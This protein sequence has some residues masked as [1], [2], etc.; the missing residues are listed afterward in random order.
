VSGDHPS[1]TELTRFVSGG[2]ADHRLSALLA[3]LA[4]CSR[5]NGELSRTLLGRGEDAPTALA[6]APKTRTRSGSYD[7]IVRRATARAH[8]AK[9]RVE[10]EDAGARRLLPRLLAVPAGRREA[11]VR[12]DPRLQTYSFARDLLKRSQRVGIDDP[13]TGEQLGELALAVVG[14]LPTR[15]YGL[16][17]LTDLQ[18]E[19]WALIGNA[20]RIRSDFP[21]ATEALDRAEEVR[22][23]GSG[24]LME[25]A[26][27]ASL[28]A[29]HLRGSGRRREALDL[30]DHAIDLY[31][32]LGDRHLE[33][34]A[35]MS[36][37]ITLYEGDAPDEAIRHLDRAA[38][39]IDRTR[40]PRLPGSLEHNRAF[41]VGLAESGSGIVQAVG[42]LERQVPE[43]HLDRLRL[44]WSKAL[45]LRRL[46]RFDAAEHAL[47]SAHRGFTAA[48]IPADV[49]LL[50]L[51]L[52][53]LYL[54]T[55]RTAEARTHSAAA[56][57]TLA[58]RG[59]ERHTLRALEL[60]RTAGGLV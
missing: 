24:D 7:A 14:R 27:L 17:V 32:S 9:R 30:I 40:D 47:L 13:R 42:E 52:A 37:A 55:G 23:E 34:R 25:E 20:R 51:D 58:S 3:H 4:A 6:E 48:G 2:L 22:R 31:R 11:L 53:Q 36:K 38:R 39:L 12:S 41:W 19:A 21:G 57:A 10:T 43:G 28:R 33:G 29:T 45:L 16:T 5:C 44:T 50:D 26:F 46:E 59:L 18:A 35:L 54:D 49:A 15:R 1:L 56:L 8:A 60:F